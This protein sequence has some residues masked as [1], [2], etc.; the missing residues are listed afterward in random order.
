MANIMSDK[1]FEV[2]CSLSTYP[3]GALEL[4]EDFAMDDEELSMLIKELRKNKIKIQSANTAEGKVISIRPPAWRYAKEL[5]NQYWAWKYEDG[6]PIEGVKPKVLNKTQ[7]TE[8]E[9]AIRKAV[10][11]DVLC[12][13][14]VLAKMVNE[15]CGTNLTRENISQYRRRIGIGS[16]LTRNGGNNHRSFA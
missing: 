16:S 14:Y 4:C 10:K 9:N 12:S 11:N 3:T 8:V 1:A 15:M 7:Q 2:L 6:P 13:D 5:A